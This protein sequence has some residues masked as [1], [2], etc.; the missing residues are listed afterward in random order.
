MADEVFPEHV[1]TRYKFIILIDAR[2][3]LYTTLRV[4][5]AVIWSPTRSSLTVGALKTNP[6]PPAN[7]LRFSN[8]MSSF[9]STVIAS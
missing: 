2:R 9:L 3:M 7:R 5:G 8:W 4:A 6:T 1:N